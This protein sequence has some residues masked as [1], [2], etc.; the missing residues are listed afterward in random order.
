MPERPG[1][2]RRPLTWL[3]ASMAVIV[4]ATGAIVASAVLPSPGSGTV[5]AP[6]APPADEV[7]PS[8]A[9]EPPPVEV[10]SVSAAGASRI[11]AECAGAY[12]MDW[13]AEFGAGWVLNPAWSVGDDAPALYGTDS[14]GALDVL[15]ETSELT[16]AWL[17]PDGGDGAHGMVTSIASVS[18]EQQTAA[19][20]AFDAAGLDCF[21]ELGGTRCIAEWEGDAGPA[22][23]SHFFRDGVWIASR[24]NGPA[25]SGYTHDIVT[26]IFG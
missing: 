8:P 5:A 10:G 14:V 22:G 26:A 16:C 3:I 24:W 9:A 2:L 17:P 15:A 6:E 7:R 19:L 23:E 20:G 12:T 18:H 4:L 11:P 25:V 1:V 21:D 13:T